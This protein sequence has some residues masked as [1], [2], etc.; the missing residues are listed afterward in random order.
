MDRVKDIKEIKLNK[1]M[2]LV[3][4]VQESK[5]EL[6]VPEG[7]DSSALKHHGVIITKGKEVEDLEVG[8]VVVKFSKSN[9]P[10]FEVGD[11]KYIMCDRA[12][13]FIAVSED[14]FVLPTSEDK[15]S[16]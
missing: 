12:L 15:L 14:N 9:L 10:T 6:I 4:I 3:K 5:S 1:N 13:I 2:V 8:D 11:T 7:V 16:S